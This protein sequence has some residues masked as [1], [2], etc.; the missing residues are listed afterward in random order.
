MGFHINVDHI[1][2]LMNFNHAMSYE[3]SILPIKGNGINA[4]LK[5]IGLRSAC[6]MTI[7]KVN[8][9]VSPLG[10]RG[11]AVMCRLY[12]TDC[13]TFYED[14]SITLNTGG[15][16]TV[17][18]RKFV[19]EVLHS[20]GVVVHTE[21]TVGKVLVIRDLSRYKKFIWGQSIHIHRAAGE[22]EWVPL[23]PEPCVVH[24]VN[25]RAMGD[26]RRLNAPFMEYVIPLIKI[27]Y[28]QGSLLSREEYHAAKQVATDRGMPVGYWPSHNIAETLCSI[29]RGDNI[30]DWAD[31]LDACALISAQP[32]S[33]PSH[34]FKYRP[35]RIVKVID[36]VLK[37][38]YNHAVFTEITLP[39]GEVAA[40]PNEKY[41]RSK[42]WG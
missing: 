25:R 21:P 18:T 37:Y 23:D 9:M 24:R 1:P 42:Y 30:E 34:N 10:K 41:I 8:S 39:L 5:P 31:V 17:S 29:M 15:W 35:D 28:P 14:D 20:M 26:V 2:H 32:L 22:I 36:E 38:G 40:N 33:W 13:V 7:R 11:M 4:G 12:G 16:E 6:H 19:S 27:A 3:A